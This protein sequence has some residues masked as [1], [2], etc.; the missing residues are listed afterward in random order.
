MSRKILVLV[1]TLALLLTACAQ[2]TQVPT[3]EPE[4]TKTQEP[5]DSGTPYPMLRDQSPVRADPY[6]DDK[7][8]AAGEN[9]SSDEIKTL[10]TDFAPLPDDHKLTMGNA[11]VEIASS[12]VM[13]STES[14]STEIII[15]LVGNLPNPCYNLRVSAHEPDKENNIQIDVY[16]VADANKVCADVLQPFDETISLGE[17]S[18][19]EYT[20][21][22]N[23]EALGKIN[24]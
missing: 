3:E 14:D 20:I 5:D 6:P 2:T 17:Y 18:S 7:E 19:G 12:E 22:I 15:H 1:L 21:F 24:Q 4:K 11:Y 10:N 8:L 16:S 9:A 13:L 23:E